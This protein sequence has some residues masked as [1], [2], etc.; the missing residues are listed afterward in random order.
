MSDFIALPMQLYADDPIWVPPLLAQQRAL[1]SKRNPYFAHA[2]WQAWLAWRGDVPVGR[3]SAQIDDRYLQQHHD[4][5]GFFGLLEAEDQPQTFQMLLHTVEAWLQAAGMRRCLGPFNLSINNECGILVEGF[6]TPPMI[7]MGHNKPYYARQLEAFG[8][9]GVQ[10][11]LAYQL[12]LDELHIPPV[13]QALLA[14]SAPRVQVR[15]LRRSHYVAEFALLRQIFNDAWANNWGFVPFTESEFQDIGRQLIHIIDDDFVQ[16]ADVDGEP[17]AMVVLLP[18]LNALIRDLKG[19][20]WPLGWLK[21]LWRLRFAYPTTARIPLMGI[22]Q[23]YQRHSLG[24]LLI[25]HLLGALREPLRRRGIQQ[26]ELSWI[27]EGNRGVR[28]IIEALGSR[29]YKRYRI[30]GRTW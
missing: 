11:L 5:T 25:V 17:A 6:G 7:L 15:A 22:R 19:R 29:I 1:L 27:L 14:K 16:I 26:I 20:L 30:Y 3:I 23:R 24:T 13:M 10:D 18:N 21:L 12:T 8:Y 4:E 28:H 9:Q 2:R